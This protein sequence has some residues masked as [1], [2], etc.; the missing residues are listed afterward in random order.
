MQEAVP[1][2]KGKMI[3]ILGIKTTEIIDILKTIEK[4]KGICQIANDNAEGQVIVSGNKEKVEFLQNILKVC[5]DIAVFPVGLLNII[6][7]DEINKETN[8]IFKALPVK[9]DRI[10]SPNYQSNNCGVNVNRCI[11]PKVKRLIAI[12]DVHGD[13]SATIKALKLANVIP[14]SISNNT[15]D[16]N[17]I[18]WSGGNTVVVQLGEQ[19]DRV[20]PSNLINNICSDDDPELYQDEGS[21]LKIISLFN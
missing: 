18:N 20:R 9:K 10:N 3:A 21:D 1:V 12:G 19:I 16:V 7:N 11:Y 13:L 4:E 8:P 5:Y 6:A 15:M 17:K 14:L 2:G